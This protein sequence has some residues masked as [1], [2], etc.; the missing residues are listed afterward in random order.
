MSNETK[1]VFSKELA[2]KLVNDGFKIVKTEINLKDPKFKV[3]IFE[4]SE[5][6][7]NAIEAYKNAKLKGG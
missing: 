5:E 6:L 4:Y 2:N 7:A 3:F 1:V